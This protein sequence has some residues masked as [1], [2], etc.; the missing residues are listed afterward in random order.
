V[1]LV[2]KSLFDSISDPPKVKKHVATLQ[3]GHFVTTFSP[4]LT[5]SFKIWDGIDTETEVCKPGSSLKVFRYSES[6][7]SQWTPKKNQ[8]HARTLTSEIYELW[9]LKVRCSRT[10]LERKSASLLV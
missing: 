3:S 6:K 4:T 1:I 8:K 5:I 7:H 10:F 9:I 2:K